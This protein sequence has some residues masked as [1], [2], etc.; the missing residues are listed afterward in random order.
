MKTVKEISKI[1]GI[2]I[3]TLRYYDEIGLLKPAKVTE[4]GYRLYDEQELEKLQEILFYKEVEIPLA[5]IKKIM[6]NP[7]YDKQKALAVQKSLLERKRNRL[8][9]IIELIDDVRKGV[10]TMSFSAFTQED[11]KKIIDHSL[12]VQSQESLDAIIEQL[13]SLENYRASMEENLK[14]ESRT[15]KLIKIYGSKD[16]AVDA[17]LAATG[18]LDEQ[19]Q[20]QSEIDNI[21]KR[22]AIAMEKQDADME[23]E[24]VG[25]LAEGY[26][27]LLRLDNARYVLLKTADDYL[28]NGVLTKATDKQ[29]GQGVTKYI[30]EGIKR[31]YGV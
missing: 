21:Y 13:G 1:T 20:I 11:V 23:A 7:E 16:K 12:E 17:S 25:K 30:G 5:E 24:C 22:F 27:K 15:A 9:G 8:N 14:N 26:K 29:Y 4:A 2:S 3:R 18:N 6:E 28:G 19:Q 31:Y 10:N